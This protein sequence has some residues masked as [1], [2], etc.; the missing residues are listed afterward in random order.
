MA[1]CTTFGLCN[2]DPN[3][4]ISGN[5]DTNVKIWDFRTGK[6]QMTYKAHNQPITCVDSSPDA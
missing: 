4:L 6:A 2:E 5:E 1:A 3:I